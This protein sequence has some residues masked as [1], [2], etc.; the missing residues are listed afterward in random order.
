MTLPDGKYCR[1][2]CTGRVISV[3]LVSNSNPL[4]Y[5]VLTLETDP[6]EVKFF[7]RNLTH[8]EKVDAMKRDQV[9]TLSGIITPDNQAQHGNAPY[10]LN[11]SSIEVY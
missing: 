1:W 8:F 5:R 10:F 2:T 3:Q 6:G 4:S 9:V 7:I 11:P